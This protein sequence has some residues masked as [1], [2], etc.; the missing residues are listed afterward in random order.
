MIDGRALFPSPEESS[1]EHLLSLKERVE[2]RLILLT[3][4]AFLVIIILAPFRPLL[5]WIILGLLVTVFFALG[6][7]SW[8]QT[9]ARF[10]VFLP[11]LIFLVVAVFLF[12]EGREAGLSRPVAAE[13]LV[14]SLLAWLV[15]MGASGFL[16]FQGLIQAGEAWRLPPFLLA[17]LAL[18]GRYLP[19]MK[20]EL[21]RQHRS[22]KLRWGEKIPWSRRI[23]LLKALLSHNFF[24][25]LRRAQKIHQSILSR[26][27]SG[28][29]VLTRKRPLTWSEWLWLGILLILV[30]GAWLWL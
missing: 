23:Y 25:L 13:I 14:R 20:E 6:R 18:S 16:D 15:L 29:W 11:L 19:L 4:L 8:R 24:L 9:L 22:L 2:P 5:K 30:G 10:L 7:L 1:K 27:F 21:N 3:I 12:P 28:K 17:L 26:N